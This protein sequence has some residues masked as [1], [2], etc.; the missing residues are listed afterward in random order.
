VREDNEIYKASRKAHLKS[1]QLRE[2]E[3]ATSE[4]PKDGCEHV[5]MT[6]SGAGQQVGRHLVLVPDF[7]FI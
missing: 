5:W 3:P 2:S 4:V 6:S 1:L 7:P